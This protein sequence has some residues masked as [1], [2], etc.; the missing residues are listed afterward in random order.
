MGAEQSKRIE[1]ISSKPPAHLEEANKL[2]LSFYGESIEKMDFIHDPETRKFYIQSAND[3]EDCGAVTLTD[4]ENK[5]KGNRKY[6]K[7]ITRNKLSSLDDV[8]TAKA[9]KLFTTLDIILGSNVGL[10]NGDHKKRV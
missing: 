9:K 1:E 6:C 7:I 3:L 2:F 4:P 10:V 5:K 8:Q